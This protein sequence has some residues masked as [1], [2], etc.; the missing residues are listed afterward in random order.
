MLEDSRDLRVIY[1]VVLDE[2]LLDGN[3]RQNLVAFRTILV[4]EVKQLMTDNVYK[5]M[6]GKEQYPQ[7]A[8]I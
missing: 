2:L 7:A 1:N 5:N 8:E 6:I 3:S 4:G